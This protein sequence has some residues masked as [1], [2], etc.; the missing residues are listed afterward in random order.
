M[1]EKRINPE[2]G[3]FGAFTGVF[4][5]T[6]LTILGLILF[7]RMGWVVGQAGLAGALVIIIMANVISFITGL[8]LS[9][10]AT[11]MHV[12]AGGT[13]YMIARTLGLEIGGAI[14]LPLFLSQA[15][16][17]AFYII[18]FTEAFISTVPLPAPRLFATSILLFFGFLAYVGAHFV[19]RLQTLILAALA[20]ALLSFFLAPGEFK[21]VVWLPPT[22][23]DANL[24]EVFAIFFPAVTGIMVGV[25]MSGDLRNPARD[26]PLGTLSAIGLTTLIYLGVAIWLAGGASTDELIN[27]Q[28]IIYKTARWPFLILI[29]VWASTLSS[30]LG[31]ILAAPRTLEA[32][33]RDHAAPRM[34]AGRMG[35]AT[36]PR[37]AVILTTVLATCVIWMGDLNFVT[38]IITM[39]FLNTYGMINLAAGLETLVGNPSFR[40]QFR[41]PWAVSL[42]GAAGCYTAMFLISAWATIA[43][44]IASYGVYIL[45]ERRS[46]KQ[47]WGDLRSGFW[48]ATS[49]FALIRLQGKPWRAKNWR[50]N[51]TVFTGLGTSR[52]YLRELGAWLCTGRGFVTFYHLLTGDLDEMTRRGLRTTAIRHIQ[53]YLS[54]RGV[55]AFA[56]AAIVDDFYRGVATV[57]QSHGIAGLEPNTALLGWSEEPEIQRKQLMLLRRLVDLKKSVLFMH[58][59]PERGYGD[60]ALI[61]V[62]WRGRDRNAELMIILAHLISRSPEWEGCEIRVLRLLNKSAGVEGATRHIADILKK[63]RVDAEPVVLVQE[64][65]GLGFAEILKKTSRDTDLVILGM[66]VPEIDEFDRYSGEIAFILN[67][68]VSTLLVRSGEQEDI[69]ET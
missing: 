36:E 16:S 64:H 33:A 5:P 61:D 29:G 58:R 41:V 14:G 48:F 50:P 59:D 53:D 57:V 47:S 43:A 15:A 32:I 42:L 19:L 6:V 51:I 56:N 2:S 28:M 49:R 27:E 7:L 3:R 63:A 44:I 60:R 30:A 34:F 24:V 21:T 67:H 38:P 46:L 9:A 13:Y 45:L 39:F 10:V 22:G 66:R 8:S 54:E 52:E 23:A 20:L 62:W 1:K 40:P 65:P 4:I 12:G 18:G 31:S 17:T 11:N 26:I 25:S 69:L 35:S 37:V 55:A 68:S